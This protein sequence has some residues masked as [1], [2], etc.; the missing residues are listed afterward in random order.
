MFIM[1]QT[2]P[3]ATVKASVMRFEVRLCLNPQS[4]FHFSVC[5]LNQI[6]RLNSK[7]CDRR[8]FAVRSFA[9]HYVSERSA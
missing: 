8:D 3:S 7:I 5:L 4:T 6:I 9:R 2:T 1:M